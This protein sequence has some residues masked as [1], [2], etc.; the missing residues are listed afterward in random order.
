MLPLAMSESLQSLSVLALDC[1]ATGA[2]PVHG[3]LLELGWALCSGGGLL[4]PL[5]SRF[6]VPR[7]QRPVRRAVRELTGWSEACLAESIE[8]RELWRRF[9]EDISQ[10]RRNARQLP[11]IIHFAR[12]ELGFL[13]DLHQR[14]SDDGGDFPLDV[15]CLHAVASRLFPD[16]PRRSIRAVAGYLGHAPELMRRSSGHVEATAFIW[17][18]CLPLLAAV[19]VSTWS[20]LKLWL[21]ETKAKRRNGLRQ[22]P[23]ERAHRLALPVGPGVYRFERRSG[24]VLYVG[25]ATSLKK[26]VASH[27]KARGPA[28]ERALELLSQV[29]AVSHVATASALEAAL[30]ECEEI[31]RL[32]PPYNVQFRAPGD[33]HAWFASRDLTESVA[34]P[35]DEHRIG[36]LPSKRAVASLVALARLC[37]HGDDARTLR[38]AALAVPQVFL[39]DT[40]LFAE[41]LRFFLEQH[42]GAASGID[43]PRLRARSLSL[44]LEYGRGESESSLE[45]TESEVPTDEPSPADWDVP[46]VVRRLER[47]LIQV[48][49]LL[50]RA[51]WLCLLAEAT[52]SYAERDMQQA[53]ALV[54]SG[55]CVCERHDLD[56]VAQVTGLPA[57]RRCARLQGQQSFDKPAYHRMRVLLTELRRVMGQG[58]GVAVRWGSRTLS[59]ARLEQLLRDV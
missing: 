30:L 23:L 54:I 24:D 48:G 25:K 45:A 35:D 19:G 44:W 27:F 12:F 20:E 47:N 59:G 3:D 13:H 52:V 6:V 4:M 22:F 8:E 39:P 46:R 7:T 50:R 17:R 21:G 56:S 55:A 51:R 1:Q 15:V 16:L 58:G 37:S 57:R 10:L 9:G 40:E 29:H 53:R 34:V 28:S 42:F 31:E 41:G 38:A 49:L 11:C 43:L 36:P 2:S 14:L 26:R 5:Q 32:D 18:E 33:S